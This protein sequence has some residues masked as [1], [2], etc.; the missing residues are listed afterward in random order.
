M[1]TD[2]RCVVEVGIHPGPFYVRRSDGKPF[3]SRHVHQMIESGYNR[4]SDFDSDEDVEAEWCCQAEAVGL[5]V[6]VCSPENRIHTDPCGWMS[7]G[8]EG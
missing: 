1:A 5:T 4:L 2:P 8:G 3:C 6:G 7:A